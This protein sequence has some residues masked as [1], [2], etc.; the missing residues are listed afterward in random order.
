MSYFGSLGNV[1]QIHITGKLRDSV[2]HFIAVANP[3]CK[4]NDMTTLSF[5]SSQ[6][7]WI[8][9]LVFG[10]IIGLASSTP[11]Q[12]PTNN[13]GQ[14]PPSVHQIEQ[15]IQNV[16]ASAGK[17][18]V[19]IDDGDSRGICMS[20]VI[21]SGDG[22]VLSP[23]ILWSRELLN[24]H[25]S[26]GR[27]VSAKPLGWSSEWGIGVLKIVDEGV[28]PHVEIGST[29]D[30]RVGQPCVVIGYPNR[31]DTKYD[32]A[33]SIGYGAIEHLDASKW[34][35]TTMFVGWY[36]TPPVFSMDGKLLG[37]V[38]TNSDTGEAATAAEVF[39]EN[40]DD[41]V[42]GKNLDWVRF[43]PREGTAH[44]SDYDVDEHLAPKRE[45][46]PAN[47][48]KH[49]A[50]DLAAARKIALDTTVRLVSKSRL[51]LG[52]PVRWS[53]VIV[54]EDG[55]I[56]T[57][58][59]TDQLPGEEVTVRLSDGRDFD[60]VV[61][62][63]NYI[64][65]VGLVKITDSGTWP[66]AKIADSSRLAVGDPLVICGYPGMTSDRKPSTDRNPVVNDVALRS[67]RPYLLWRS[68]IPLTSHRLQGGMSG[69]GV[70]DSKGHHVGVFVGGVALRS[71]IAKVQWDHLASVKP[72]PA[73]GKRPHSVIRNALAPQA[74]K[75]SASVVEIVVGSEQVALGTIVRADGWIITKASKLTGDAKCKLTDGRLLS[76][77]LQHVACEQDLAF[78][79]VDAE[80]LPVTTFPAAENVKAGMIIAAVLPGK[81]PRC[82]V[83]SVET[84]AVP[85]EASWTGDGLSDTPSGLEVTRLSF[86]G[87]EVAQRPNDII[88]EINGHP[89]PDVA[90][91]KRLLGQELR[92]TIPGDLIEMK[93]TRAGGEMIFKT[94]L[95][96]ADRDLSRDIDSSYT[97][98]RSGFA[99]VFDTDIPLK[100][101]WCGGPVMDA[102]GLTIGV[103]IASRGRNDELRGPTMVLPASLVKAVTDQVL[104]SQLSATPSH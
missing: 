41:L 36:E 76:A 63:T 66:F 49:S 83:V 29:R 16:Y 54:S 34:F 24:V 59:H 43:P 27:T 37:I 39:T 86:S 1:G 8:S 45:I 22:Y 46:G 73:P 70:F 99:A 26:D 62:G 98:R 11:A 101:S 60:G 103:V 33:P 65:D 10:A 79:K 68:H 97:L 78:L 48:T 102:C 67:W 19:R 95:L 7:R 2:I 92:D 50:P 17:A 58:G 52:A 18:V 80:D 75:S 28:W 32:R 87:E 93:V 89:T 69:G 25:L 42:A 30:A 5:P 53:G 3:N 64:S 51:F 47:E 88:R 20:G 61:L 57:C 55:H 44:R 31:G 94:P 91:L 100:Q 84:R 12:T 96:P 40:W 71:E 35:T 14:G 38:V 4:N 104:A 6:H 85:A 74:D 81:P 9:L 56:L 15:Q 23:G 13:A 72:F 77:E 82:G 21:V 90:S